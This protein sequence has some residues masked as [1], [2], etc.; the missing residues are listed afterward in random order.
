MSIEDRLAQLSPQQRALLARRLGQKT[1]PPGAPRIPTQPRDGRR[2][3][4]SFSQERLWFEHLLD[5]A[6]P[7]YNE[8]VVLRVRGPLQLRWLNGALDDLVAQHEILRTAIVAE[9]NRAEQAILPAAPVPMARRALNAVDAETVHAVIR[10]EIRRPFV[11]AAPPLLRLS[12]LALGPDEHIIVFVVHHIVLDGWSAAGLFRDIFAAY[13]ARQRGEGL[14]PAAAGVT[15]ADFAV[16][17]RERFASGVLDGELDYWLRQLADAPPPPALPLDRPRP[18]IR[19]AAGGRVVFRCDAA[20]SAAVRALAQRCEATVFS[21]LAAVY[22]VL[23]ARVCEFDELLLAVPSTTRDLPE[24]ES[25]VGLFINTLVLRL[26]VDGAR[27]FVDA[28]ALVNDRAMQARAHQLYP[29]EHLVE[30]LRRGGDLGPI[31]ATALMFDVQK[32]PAG[33]APAGL[34]IDYLDVD[35]GTSKFDLGLS[36]KD[37]GEALVGT[38]EYAADLFDRATIAG[39]ADQF[40]TLLAGCVA[41]P[42]AK[43]RDLALMS[44]DAAS[45]ALRAGIGPE[46]EM[47]RERRLHPLF[48]TQAAA[49][50]DALA[51]VCGEES[52][53]YAA[54]DAAANRLAQRLVKL[55][56][57]PGD[58]VAVQL[59]RSVELI[60]AIFG[61]LKAGSAYVPVDVRWPVARQASMIS[62]C[63]ARVVVAREDGEQAPVGGI[64]C[65]PLILDEPATA[66]DVD[67]SAHDPAYVL[68]TSGSTGAPRGVVVSHRA[69]VNL[70]CALRETVY[71][72]FGTG[73]RVAVNGPVAFDTSVKQIIQ[74]LGGHT[75]DVIPE[76]VRTDPAALVAYLDGHGVEVLD[77]TPTQLAMLLAEGLLS[78]GAPALKAVLVGGEPIDEALWAQAAASG[79]RA[80]NLYGPT[81]CT[82]D[83]T[84]TEITGACPHIGRALPNVRTYVLDAA[85][86]PVPPGMPGELYIG[87]AGVAEGYVHD[88][89]ETARRFLS[90]PFDPGRVYRTGDRVRRRADGDL[91]FLGRADAQI[92]L[93]GYRIEPSEVVA[94]LKQT[95]GVVD[96]TVVLHGEGAHQRLVAYVVLDAVCTTTVN[97]QPRHILP[98]GLAVAQLNRNETDFLYEEMFELEAYFRHGVEL[99]AGDVVFDVGAN[100][101]LFTL[102][103]HLAAPDVTIHAFEPN[104]TVH[105]IA[106]ANAGLYGVAA[107]VHNM[108]LS[109]APGTATFTFYPGFSFLSGLHADRAADAD[110]VRSFVRKH[111]GD[112]ADAFEPALLEELLDDRLASHTIDVTLDTLS[113]VM[114][115]EGVDHIDL[116]KI[117]VEKS[118]AQVLAGIADADWPKIRQIALELHDMDGRLEAVLALLK[119]KGFSVTVEQDWRLED[120]AKTNYYLYAHRGPRVGV[121]PAGAD[122][123]PILDAERLRAN[124]AGRLPDYMVPTDIVFLQALPMTVNGKLDRRALPAP[125][126]GAAPVSATPR[127]ETE[128]RL[129]AV[130]ASVLHRDAVGIH[131]DFFRIGGHSLLA[132]LLMAQ[133]RT[134]F[135]VALP[136]RALFEAPTVAL[137]AARL[138][139]EPQSVGEGLA[140]MAALPELVP[141]P[142]TWHEP[143]PLTPIQEAYWMGRTATFELGQAATQIY[144]ELEQAGWELPRIEATWNRLVIRHDMLRAIILSEERQQIL[145]QVPY[146]AIACEDL[147][148]RPAAEVER[149]LQSVRETMSGQT[150]PADRWPLFQIR[151]TQMDGGKVRLHVGVDALIADAASLFLLF[152]EWRRGY[153]AGGETQP[154]LAIGF[155]DYVL[156]ERALH[157]GALYQAAQR[158][159][160]DRLDTL[161]P[162]PDLPVDRAAA[163]AVDKPH[164]V[165]RSRRL[166]PALWAGLKE[167]A[168]KA[169]LT[170]SLVLIAA[171]AEALGTWSANPRFT[172][173]LTTFNRLPLHPDVVGLMGDFTTLTLLAADHSAPASF[174]ERARALQARLWDDLEHRYISGVDVLR[175]LAQR[176]RSGVSALMPVVFTSA[177]DIDPA[178][179]KTQRFGE[180]VESVSQT[181]QVWLDHQ[182]MEW[183]GALVLNWDAVESIF[184]AGMLDDFATAHGD[185]VERLATSESA[186][187]TWQGNLAPAAQLARRAAIN[188]TKETFPSRRLEAG[189]LGHAA[190]RP[191]AAAVITS[192]RT[193]SY[194]ELLRR[195]NEIAHVLRARGQGPGTLVAVVMRKDWEQIAAALGILMAG[196]AYLPI[197]P[198]LPAERRDYLL[199]HCDVAIALTQSA[200]DAALAWPSGVTR[201]VVDLLDGQGER[202]DLPS[203]VGSLSLDD[204]AYVLFTSGSTGVPKGVMISQRAIANSIADFTRRYG[205]TAHDRTFGLSALGFDLSVFDIFCALSA[206]GAIVLPDADK[207][208][209]PA[210]WAD[211]AR[212]HSVT[213]WQSV[214][215]LMQMLVEDL[216]PRRD[217][218][219]RS[220]RCV[221]MSGDWIPVALPDRIR[222]F[223]PAI[224]IHGQGGAT[225]TSINAVVYPIGAVDPAWRSIPYGKPFAN[226]TAHIL[227]ALLEPT[228]VWVPG[229]LYIGGVGLAE[230]YWKDAEKTAAA[231]IR[232]PRT[233][234]RLYRTGDYGRYLPDGNIEF[235]GRRD[236]Q[237]K[238]NGHRIELGEIEGALDQHP[239][240]ERGVVA[241]PAD[242]QGQRRLVAYV[243]RRQEETPA[244]EPGAGLSTEGVLS[245]PIARVTFKLNRHGLPDVAPDAPAVALPG[246]AFDDARRAAWLERQ[247]FR[248]FVAESVSLERLAAVLGALQELPMDGAPLPKFRYP[249]AG[250]LYP[251]RVYVVVKDGRVAGLAGGAYV[252]DPSGHRLVSVGPQAAMAPLYPGPNR[253]LVEASAFSIILVGR[254]AAVEPMYGPLWRDFCLLEAGY[255]GQLLSSAAP[256]EQIGLCPLGFLADGPTRDLLHLDAADV[257]LHSFAGGGITPAQVESWSPEEVPQQGLTADGVRAFLRSKLPDYMVPVSV[258][259]LD[260]LPLNANGKVDRDALPRP[261]AAIPVADAGA[262]PASDVERTIAAVVEAVLQQ[263]VLGLDNNFFDLGANSVHL[264]QIHRKLQEALGRTFPL[265]DLFQN[266]SI[267]RLAVFLEDGAGELDTDD[268]VA[269]V[270]RARQDRSKRLARRRGAGADTL[271]EAET[272]S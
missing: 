166:S 245:D 163:A 248:H 156:A 25:A 40:L 152:D 146:Y 22:A 155:R 78:G 225:E 268:I 113:N 190:A 70:F 205:F 135:N 20:V 53:S 107:T 109:E 96:A 81:E 62:A 60:V 114:A 38:F 79:V 14:P 168:A 187:T 73:L 263:P 244:E 129:A 270:E 182:V 159:W 204:L 254:R 2:F 231:F 184:P 15:Y 115:R 266:P 249:S 21:T 85:Q 161:P 7:A 171:Y 153:E 28:L 181:P 94:A 167:R 42:D 257:V 39:L 200:V 188:D 31:P 100:I 57:R 252:Y 26:P 92:K 157:Q 3:P 183:N 172:L 89:E 250:S 91:V 64:F 239:Q 110:V 139:A 223:D 230:G 198:D 75:L 186:W 227:D 23:L 136:L 173:N 123:A 260:T 162:A 32:L 69:V 213:V 95:E 140:P 265:V 119:A 84:W 233:G 132:T 10:E 120:S 141:D 103:A 101:G 124:L 58:C 82:V 247:S 41:R 111:D 169:G 6:S 234:E 240:V 74:L 262:A 12:V 112:S 235:L 210:H 206:G 105:A 238:V 160:F 130:W 226:Q 192:R 144:L 236:T 218:W 174:L 27:A 46:R 255:M 17:E 150:L 33:I 67:V 122:I 185:L 51:V 212:R 133:V 229:E 195:A 214:P 16:W 259:F 77:A 104:P 142:A 191:A 8:A 80:F 178:G 251:V 61:I 215:V 196:V 217:L 194:G 63:G 48:A 164:F 256:A 201:I 148:G 193:L 52:L 97:G 43:I 149:H 59:D 131:D 208:R 158:Y 50:P 145:A 121:R 154:P 9:G 44:P 165:R 29:Y 99:R 237:V 179:Q 13:G 24:L 151:A 106:T 147:R 211:L 170:P 175:A 55:G 219:P 86:H 134:A 1:Q 228:P 180:V 98:N 11:L 267:R 90:L 246:G 45:A 209:D 54:L 272:A 138:D 68:Y 197:D 216:E 253:P 18:V 117:N 189:F 102:S 126:T 30:R 258:V 4:L 36:I 71:A 202:A 127:T 143:F 87:G 261:D 128:R 116:L 49:T 93:R 65:G 271:S 88:P 83:A 66:P 137:L 243:V 220:L 224:A 72:G 221:V 5:P 177:L 108:G 232:H 203:G 269:R 176:R 207:L 125:A 242:A 34:A 118:E 199:G 264:V 37:E 76:A 19:T 56:V 35:P 222:A 47:G 241:A